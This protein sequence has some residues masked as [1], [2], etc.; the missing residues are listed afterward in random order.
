MWTKGFDEYSDRALELMGMT[1]CNSSASP[2]L[3]KLRVDDDEEDLRDPGVYRF[4]VCTLLYLAQRRPDTQSTARWLH[5]RL[6]KPNRQS[7]RQFR[8]LLRHLKGAK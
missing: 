5:K 3:D 6:M 4:T 1:N 2:K 8:V 7:D